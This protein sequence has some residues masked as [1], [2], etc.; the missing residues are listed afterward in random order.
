MSP[1]LPAM[2]TA[3]KM[4]IIYYGKKRLR[5][6]DRRVR[7]LIKRLEIAV[8]VD[9]TQQKKHNQ[10]FFGAKVTYEDSKGQERAVRI[11]K[12]R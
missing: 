3:Q 4:V 11:V 1:G 8:I 7:Y 5:E 6:I 9:I 10:V 12:H 2:A